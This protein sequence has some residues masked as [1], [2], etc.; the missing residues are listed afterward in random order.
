MGVFGHRSSRLHDSAPGI[1][2]SKHL[3]LLSN[4]GVEGLQ[5]CIEIVGLIWTMKCV[6][7]GYRGVVKTQ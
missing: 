3:V 1:A 6:Y 2:A 4:A 5:R 7:G